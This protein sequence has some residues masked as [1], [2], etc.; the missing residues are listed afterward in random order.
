MVAEIAEI[1]ERGHKIGFY[2]GWKEMSSKKK[3]FENYC[4]RWQGR[5]FHFGLKSL[6]ESESWLIELSFVAE[7]EAGTQ[8]QGRLNVESYCEAV[9][10]E[11]YSA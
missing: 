8:M 1:K 5:S 7:R 10:K 4:W 11:E 2:Q 3:T 9:C 6:A